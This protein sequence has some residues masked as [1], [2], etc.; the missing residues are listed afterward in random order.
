MACKIQY[1]KDKFTGIELDIAASLHQ[2]IERELNNPDIHKFKGAYYEFTTNGSANIAR[3]NRSRKLIGEI[4][5]K[6]NGKVITILPTREYRINVLPIVQQFID[7][8]TGQQNMFQTTSNTV[9]KKNQELD[10]LLKEYCTINGIR[11][12]YLSTLLDKFG[13]DYTAVYFRGIKQLI[14]IN[15]GRE[16][17]DTLAE[18]VS[19]SVVESLGDEDFLVKKALNLI[20]KT[21][22]KSTLDPQYIKLYKNNEV[23]LKKEYL[24]KLMAEA[25]VHKFEPKTANELTL[26]DTI[27]KLWGKFIN[28]FKPNDRVDQIQTIVDQLVNKIANK[29]KIVITGQD[30]PEDTMYFQVNDK[31]GIN[32]EYKKQYVYFK[33]RIGQLSTEI[34]KYEIGSKKYEDLND[35][36]IEIEKALEELKVS[37]NKQ[38]VID[39]GDKLLNKIEKDFITMI[40]APGFDLKTLKPKNL[41]YAA[42]TLKA[43]ITLPNEQGIVDLTSKAS[44]LYKRLKGVIEEFSILEANKYN[45]G[46][47][48]ITVEKIDNQTKDIN[49][50]IKSFGALADSANILARTIAAMIKAA[51]NKISTMN[52]KIA[53]TIEKEV[54]A[55]RDYSKINGISEDNMYDIFIQEYKDTTVLT[56]EY[57]TE[58]YDE[59][60]K[61][62]GDSDWWNRNAVKVDD[63]WKP[64]SS[65]YDNSNYKTIQ[66]TPELKKFYDFHKE[67]IRLAASKLPRKLGENFIANIRD[68][69]L[70]DSI[71][72]A[73]TTKGKFISALSHL[74]DVD[75]NIFDNRKI[76]SDEELFSDTIPVLYTKKVKASEKS[77]DLGSNLLT[78]VSF[79]NSYAELNDVLPAAR[80]LQEEIGAKT[81]TK[82][83]DPSVNIL[84]EQSNIYNLVKTVIDMQVKG[85]T[86]NDEAKIKIENIYDDEGNKIGEKYIHG[87]QFLDFGLRYNS[88]LRIGFNPFNA[89]ANV[90]VGDIGNIIEAFGSR[91][92]GIKDLK[93]ATDVFF[94]QNWKDDSELNK[95]LE[96]LNPLQ[97]LEDYE[98]VN[99]VSLKKGLN[100][101][102]I[103]DKMY[104]PQRMG[105]KFLQTRTMLAMLI[106]DGYMTSEGITTEKGLA[107]TPDQ[108]AKFSDKVQ[109]VNQMIHGRYSARDA[110]IVQQSALW[111]AAFQFKKWIPA[112]IESRIQAKHFD[113]RLGV[114]VEGRYRTYFKYWNYMI[115]KLKNDQKALIN[116]ELTELDRYNMRKNLTEL[117]I[118]ASVLLSYFALGWDD[119]K[120]KKKNPYYKFAMNQLNRVSGDLAFF[121]NPAEVNRSMKSPFALSKT[122]GDTIDVFTSIQYAFDIEGSTYKKGIHKGENK[123]LASLLDITPG[124]KPIADVIRMNKDI[125]YEEPVKLN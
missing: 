28:L 108:L 50:L 24:G 72:S 56:K 58:W 44:K 47:E 62:Q 63:T 106:K 98:N 46:E 11:L 65:K 59:M 57:T 29:N 32:P 1:L 113:N 38:I 68:V 49:R 73:K 104:S 70:L 21:D 18:E 41:F 5:N 82:S 83:S 69:T 9:D 99:K 97:E 34:Q 101:E 96:K 27:L 109:R 51:Q 94:K 22:Y 45:T 102:K 52:K 3:V 8:E 103:K 121:Y 95:W 2:Q 26:L 40:D 23:A 116:G 117:V 100:A 36:L 31:S 80:L 77:K 55:L 85:E 43:F 17:K 105:E 88:L 74:T 93:K 89:V 12:E 7:K 60:Q 61:H 120:N 110:A 75:V 42:N 86:K 10:N 124:A 122:I 14:S 25:L 54:D 6:Y 76:T 48:S 67:L 64:I 37:D 66:R 123:F 13:G 33:R 87:S 92:Y 112:A 15:Q 107:L 19:H 111:R 53:D 16:R 118:M 81:Y 84:G 78:F 90:L 30:I 71:K 39:L 79:A 91:F 115:A 4:N 125:A 119:D 114:E 35:E 20:G